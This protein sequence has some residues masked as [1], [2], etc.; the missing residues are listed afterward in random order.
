MRRTQEPPRGFTVLMYHAQRSGGKWQKR[1]V[2]LLESGQLISSKKA[3][4]S[5]SDRDAQSLC[6]LSDFDIYTPTEAQMRRVLKPPKKF[7]FAVKSQQKASVFISNPDNFV[8]Y[9][10]AEDDGTA[11][12]FHAMV[13]GWR[14][15]YLVNKKIDMSDQAP[16][17]AGGGK[18]SRQVLNGNSKT[19]AGMARSGGH[20]LRVSVDETPYTL[21][22]FEPLLDMTRF[23]KPLEDFGRDFRPARHQAP[24]TTVQSATGVGGG[25]PPAA[26]SVVAAAAAA[27]A[28]AA[29]A[30][31]VAEP[32][33]S[34]GRPTRRPWRCTTASRSLR[35]A[36]CSGTGMRSGRSSAAGG[37]A[38]RWPSPRS[39][40]GRRS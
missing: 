16:S 21:G 26:G 5:L 29:A 38:R 13:H 12:T 4:A 23:E 6:H 27:A 10:C 8:H 34:S 32:N 37:G 35:S 40:A 36:A 25:G 9:F 2:S 39:S 14:S 17:V 18:G 24:P 30:G 1:Y 11:D 22:T 19:A 31:P 20:R 33:A 7:C 28:T 3:D 15:W